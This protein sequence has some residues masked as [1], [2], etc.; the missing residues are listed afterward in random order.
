MRPSWTR[1]LMS[2]N[3]FSPAMARGGRGEGEGREG[4]RRGGGEIEVQILY[5][6]VHVY[7][8]IDNVR[9]C[10]LFRDL[11]NIVEIIFVKQFKVPHPSAQPVGRQRESEGEEGGREREGRGATEEVKG[12]KEGG[13]SIPDIDA[14]RSTDTF[15]SLCPILTVQTPLC[16]GE[17]KPHRQSNTI[18]HACTGHIL[19]PLLS[20][21][22]GSNFTLLQQ[23]HKHTYS[24]GCK[25]G[26]A[27]SA[28]VAP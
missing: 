22:L 21:V 19:H 9:R 26:I 11:T 3:R 7:V 23:V 20:R 16:V 15:I 6:H 27:L 10:T 24:Q 14:T 13:N 18:L 4:G 25:C 12:T 17:Y 5:V 28:Q 1:S 8:S 2:S